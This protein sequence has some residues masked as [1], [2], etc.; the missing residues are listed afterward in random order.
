MDIEG[1][2]GPWLRKRRRA[3]DLTQEEFA[4]R[5]GCARITVRKME[6]DQLRPSRQMAESLRGVLGV[7]DAER[8]RFLRFARGGSPAGVPPESSPKHN[9]PLQ[10]TSFIGREREIA[11]LRSLLETHRLVTL[12]GAG[13]VGKTRLALQL[14]SEISFGFRDGAWFIDLAPLS[15][16]ALIPSIVLRLLGLS[17]GRE[18]EP[19][20]ALTQH[21]AD[22]TLQLILDNCEHL[23]EDACRFA[24]GVL[25]AG[26][27]IRVVATSREALDVMGE[28]LY[29]VP[30][31]ATPSL[32]SPL[33]IDELADYESVRLFTDRAS[34]ALPDFGITSA[35]AAQVAQICAHLD[36]I[37]LA[38]ELAAARLCSMPL[39]TLASRLD[40]RFRLLSHGAQTV[41]PRH[42]TLRAAIDWS[43]QLLSASERLLLQR[44]TVF[45]GGN[46]VEAAE[47]VCIGEGIDSG[48]VL[49]LLARLTD[50]SM[51]SLDAHGRYRMLETVRQYAAE[52]LDVSGHAEGIRDRHLQYMLAFAEQ[53]EPHLFHDE[54]MIWLAR[55]D[56]ELDNLRAALSWAEQHEA[57]AFLRLA[58]ALWRYWDLRFLHHEG[59][60]WLEKALA[61][62]RNSRTV[63][64][65][66]ALAN[67]ASFYMNFENVKKVRQ[68]AQQS[69]ALAA[70]LEDER[71]MTNALDLLDYP[72]FF[73]GT[74]VAG[75]PGEQALASARELGDQWLIASS[76]WVLG[77]H[78]R[79]LN[80][81]DLARSF[82]EQGVD[83]ARLCGDRRQTAGHLLELG[84][85]WTA[86]GEGE[87]A[88]PLLEEAESIM[89]EMDD[90]PNMS[91]CFLYQAAAELVRQNY[92]RAKQL[93]EQGYQ[94]CSSHGIHVHAMYGLVYCGLAEWGLGNLQGLRESSQAAML[95]ARQ[96]EDR[97]AQAVALFRLGDACRLSGDDGMARKHYVHALQLSRREKFKEGYC[98]CLQGLGALA[99][100]EGDA[101]RA[102][103]F[104]AA[105][106]RIRESV[107]A[108]DY[109][110]I[111][112]RER[113][114]LMA[115]ARTQLGDGAFSKAWAEGQ[116]MSEEEMFTQALK[117][118]SG[119]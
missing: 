113:E 14:A 61:Q 15:D 52:A 21:L 111:M 109:F 74:P 76:L 88:M 55:L 118:Q 99:L 90:V 43:Y 83:A 60:E 2:F 34:L 4:R 119:G 65:A 95:A 77:Q 8:E 59:A 71:S 81:L 93:A 78:A 29:R 40:D 75:S 38:I 100:T 67:L 45:R 41:M 49:D 70:H 105:R 37:P 6:A 110:P 16:G 19:M 39:E 12:T 5:V 31:L 104:F 23:L 3:L 82:F 64:R 28:Q 18:R 63:P 85:L 11:R 73:D 89:K 1:S 42:Q 117:E 112:V 69:Y 107:L 54:Q 25:Q 102:A 35:N 50:K 98:H 24:E 30:S 9:L 58:N 47:A 68:F 86:Q 56:W 7:P 36:G 44:L 108:E 13:G 51:L 106:A 48:D 79:F 96:A 27:G 57:D 20:Q 26:T 87:R 92:R 46:S 115:Q 101:V 114:R 103:R 33:A 91:D 22:K 72:L 94:L 53:A 84:N 66:R 97:I 116:A 32:N 10:L 62:T 17:V 80:D